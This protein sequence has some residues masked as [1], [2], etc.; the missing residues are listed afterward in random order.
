MFNEPI[1]VLTGLKYY[2]TSGNTRN[3]IDF[4]VIVNNI[5]KFLQILYISIYNLYNLILLP[6]AL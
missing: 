3:F 1:G 2:T 5:P 4:T 6:T